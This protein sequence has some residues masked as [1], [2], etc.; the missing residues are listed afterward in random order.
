MTRLAQIARDRFLG[1]VLKIRSYR[2]LL[3]WQ[4]AVD[5]VVSTYRVTQGL[6]SAERFGLTVQMRRAAV[7]IPANI[8]EGW[9]RRSRADYLRFLTIANSSRLELETLIVIG[10]RLN[11]AATAEWK[12]LGAG[13]EEVG[14]MLAGLV[15]S[16]KAKP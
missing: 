7:S 10:Q 11:L 1:A 9:G 5:L 12:L 8:A 13:A 3:V 14:R 16:L 15:R 4:K 2:D 6:P